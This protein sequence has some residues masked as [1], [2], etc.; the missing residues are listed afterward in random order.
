MNLKNYFKVVLCCFFMTTVSVNGISQAKTTAIKQ[1]EAL[2]LKMFN[3]VNNRDYDAM[4]NMSHPKIYDIVPKESMKEIFKSMFE[5]NEQ[6][7]VD[8]PKIEPKYKLS[9]VYNGAKDNLEYAFVSYDMNMSM[10]FHDQ[11]FDEASKKTMVDM[12]KAKD[13]DVTFVSNNTLDIAM[14]DRVTIVLKDDSTEN[15]WVILNYDESPLLTQI[16]SSDLLQAAK[17]YKQE[18]IAGK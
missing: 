16:V 2:V 15:K 18:L 11:E 17:T 5:G 12:M 14:N 8:L 10:T 6:F 1:V 3:D 4:L 7:S 13:M 9:K